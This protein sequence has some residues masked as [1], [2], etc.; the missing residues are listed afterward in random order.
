ML[1]KLRVLGIGFALAVTLAGAAGALPPAVGNGLIAFTQSVSGTPQIFTIAPDGTGQQQLTF[2]GENIYPNWSRD[3]SQIAYSSTASGAAEIWVMNADGTSA[4]QL[5][6]GTP[7]GNFVPEWSP[8]GA[9]IAYASLQDSVGHPEVWVMNSDGT[10]PTRLTFTPPNPG[11]PTWSI[12]PTWSADG[13]TLAFASTSSGNT[14]IWTM[15]SDGTGQQQI[16]TGNG[17]GYPD[18]NASEWSRDGSKLAF[19][20]G[21]ETQFGEIWTMDPDGSNKTRLTETLDPRNS[22]NPVWAPDGTKLLFDTN[23][24]GPVELWLMDAD[25]ANPNFLVATAGGPA[26]WQAIPVPEPVPAMSSEGVAALSI[27]LLGLGVLLLSAQEGHRR[28]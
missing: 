16:T 25:G 28:I 5:T 10:A 13:Q 23:R 14:E 15:N 21:F 22:D 7:G 19:W 11:A 9:K 12:H 26:S 18:S 17:P 24:S 27:V 20:S 4:T 2:N 8:D 1:M 3:G 6:F